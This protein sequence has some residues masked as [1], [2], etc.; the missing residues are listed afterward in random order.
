M[1]ST[2]TIQKYTE[3]PESSVDILDKASRKF[4]IISTTDVG[5]ASN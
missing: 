4:F 2:K 5:T 3:K 1:I